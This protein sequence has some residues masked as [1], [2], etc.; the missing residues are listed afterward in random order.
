MYRILFVLALALFG[1][2]KDNSTTGEPAREAMGLYAKGFNTLIADPK[3]M[4]K[5]YFEKIPEEGP[6]PKAKPKLWHSTFSTSKI[7]EARDAFAAAKKAAPPALANLAKPADDA[8]AAIEKI[9]TIFTEAHKYYDAENYKDDA[10]KRGKELHAQMIEATKQFNTALRDLEDGLTVI[11]D[12]QAVVELK[13]YE[14]KQ[15]YSYW[16]RAYNIEAKKFLN[17]VSKAQ[18]PEQRAALAS[19]F[20]PAATANGALEKF[21]ASKGAGMNSAFKSYAGMAST[22]NATAVKLLRLVK[23]NAKED[24]VDRELEALVRN[25]NSLVSMAN[26]LYQIEDAN[27]LN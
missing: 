8:V 14:G 9:G 21:V 3:G 6:D 13:K 25:Y 19:A 11:E 4:I 2:K 22:Y 1:C 5:E 27:A 15:N 10:F 16:F 12:Q 26:S 7:K 18:T 20:E 23:E 17:V 24:E